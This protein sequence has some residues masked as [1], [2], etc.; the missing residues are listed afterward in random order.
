MDETENMSIQEDEEGLT[1]PIPERFI[2][3]D[4]DIEFTELSTIDTE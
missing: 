1:T 2:L 3:H 4:K